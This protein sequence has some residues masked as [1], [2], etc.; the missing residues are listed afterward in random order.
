MARHV[1]KEV[2]ARKMAQRCEIILTYSIGIAD[3]LSIEVD[4]Q[5]TSNVDEMQ[6][7][8]M[9][10]GEF[11][12]NT[13]DIIKQFNLRRPIYQSMTQQGTFLYEI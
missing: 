2:V 11:S 1:A 4:T 12:F 8:D 13:G 3:P 6:I 7:L 5:G 10:R 9:I